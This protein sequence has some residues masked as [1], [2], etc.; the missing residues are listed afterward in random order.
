VDGRDVLQKLKAADV[1]ALAGYRREILAALILAAFGFFFFKFIY[2]GGVSSIETTEALIAGSRAEIQRMDAETR[3]VESLKKTFAETSRKLALVEKRL[4]SIKERLPTDKQIS[5]ILSDISGGDFT[6]GIRI[7]SVKPMPPEVKGELTR[8]PFQ[9]TMEGRYVP[10]GNYLE[11][12]ENLPRVMAVDNFKV[13]SR[14]TGGVG[15]SPN[16]STQLYLS[17]YVFGHGR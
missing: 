11:R 1:R 12:L 14:G 4:K 5:E 13:E 2:A 15:G 7:T 16:L 3:A 10:F 17:A 9:L 8:L 6:A